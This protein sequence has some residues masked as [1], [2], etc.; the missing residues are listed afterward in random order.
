M[1]FLSPHGKMYIGKSGEVQS[2]HAGGTSATAS[3][4]KMRRQVERRTDIFTDAIRKWGWD[5]FEKFICSRKHDETACR[6][7]RR[8]KQAR[9]LPLI[10][11]FE[12][13]N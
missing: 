3:Y 10:A 4:K 6:H 2:P 11:E 12:T 5:R 8:A 1:G 9:R 13:F 7:R